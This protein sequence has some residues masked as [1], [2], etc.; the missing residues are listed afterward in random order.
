MFHWFRRAGEP[1]EV[2]FGCHAK[3]EYANIISICIIFA[4]LFVK[5]IRYECMQEVTNNCTT[6]I[7]YNVTAETVNE[8]Y[9]T[10]YVVL[11]QLFTLLADHH[12]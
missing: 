9:V 5:I 8:A 1:A 6:T 12:H 2:Q 10:N 7:N 11:T 4:A 3:D